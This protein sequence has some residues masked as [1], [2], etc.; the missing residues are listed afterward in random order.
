VKVELKAH[1][2]GP[3]SEVRRWEAGGR[4]GGPLMASVQLEMKG[5]GDA[6]APIYEGKRRGDHDASILLSTDVRRECTTQR[7]GGLGWRWRQ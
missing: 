3:D 1:F 5:R 7:G 4:R 2:I 6:R